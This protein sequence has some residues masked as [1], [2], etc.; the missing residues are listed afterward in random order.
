VL[1]GDI[2][3]ADGDGA[4]VIPAALVGEVAKAAT[5]QEHLETWIMGE[6]EGGAALPG[7]YPPNETTRARYEATKRKG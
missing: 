7:L 5:E 2:V 6:V 1:P 4:V 3:V